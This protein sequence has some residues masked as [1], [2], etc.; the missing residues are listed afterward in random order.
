MGTAL[1]EAKGA[2]EVKGSTAGGCG[3]G[4]QSELLG[5]NGTG[6]SELGPKQ[7]EELQCGRSVAAVWQCACIDVF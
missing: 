3:R 7:V 4:S 2:K 5:G 1:D 6:G